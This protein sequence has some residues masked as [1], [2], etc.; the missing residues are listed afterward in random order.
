M[1]SVWGSQG[2]TI[3]IDEVSGAS[4]SFTLISNITSIEGM[5]GGTVTAQK[6]TALNSTVH[7]YRATIKDP[8]EISISGW[9]DPTDS[10]HK[11]IRNWNDT[12]TNGPYNIQVIENT[13]AANSSFVANTVITKFTASATDVEANL[14][15]EAS[16]KITGATTWTNST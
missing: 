16:F 15:F 6:T 3:G 14:A 2:T 7:T 5:G 11:F 9:Y 1:A 12:P 8:D 4:N 10:V 13:G